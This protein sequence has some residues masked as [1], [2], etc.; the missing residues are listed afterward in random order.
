MLHLQPHHTLIIMRFLQLATAVVAL[1]SS[2]VL[3]AP[4]AVHSPQLLAQSLC[5]LSRAAPCSLYGFRS[6]TLWTRTLS[7]RGITQDKALSS[8]VES[9]GHNGYHQR[10]S[11]RGRGFNHCHSFGPN[12]KHDIRNGFLG[13]ITQ[14]KKSTRTVKVPSGVGLASLS[15]LAADWFVQA[16]QSAGELVQEPQFGTFSFTGC[17]A[18]LTSGTAVGPE[19]AGIFEIQGTSG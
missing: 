7:S 18:T 15:S 1:S 8:F 13:N 17:S 16:Y 12:C 4:R 10:R 5:R 6:E 14:N 2:T 19:K 3:K 11:S 9:P